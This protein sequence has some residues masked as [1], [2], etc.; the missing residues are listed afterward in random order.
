MSTTYELP[1]YDSRKSFYG[2]AV[3]IETPDRYQLRSYN[4]I[5]CSLDRHTG[6]FTRHWSGYSATTMRH[7]I[8][9]CKHFGIPCGGKNW[10]NELEPTCAA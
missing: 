6:E 3:I 10:W 2:K 8:S 5:V 7:I 1:C 9:F 4:T